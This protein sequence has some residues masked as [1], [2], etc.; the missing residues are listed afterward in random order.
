MLCSICH[1]MK[2]FTRLLEH[3]K[4]IDRLKYIT[5]PNYKDYSNISTSSRYMQIPQHTSVSRQLT[6]NG[7]AEFRRETHPLAFRCADIPKRQLH[8]P[9]TVHSA[10]EL[11]TIN[12]A[13]YVKVL[14]IHQVSTSSR[15][16]SWQSI[17]ITNTNI[18]K[19]V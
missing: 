17:S 9:P 11:K 8:I 7:G 19:V 14:S 16:S 2:L 15:T 10:N 5:K 12:F 4:F 13:T 3:S 18:A 1:D 6:T